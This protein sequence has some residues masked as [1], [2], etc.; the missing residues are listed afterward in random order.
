MYGAKMPTKKKT[1]GQKADADRKTAEAKSVIKYNNTLKGKKP[2]GIS[3]SSKNIPSS[4]SKGRTYK[5][6]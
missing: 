3:P 4:M 6:K 5:G 2:I 1:R